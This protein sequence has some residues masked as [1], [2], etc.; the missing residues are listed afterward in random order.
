[1]LSHIQIIP[2]IVGLALGIIG[3]LFIDPDK[4]IIYKYPNPENAGKITYKDNNGV[5]YKYNAN[6]VNCDKN[7]GKLKDYPLST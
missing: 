5:C 1:M 7:E 4:R 2:L 3:I 6:K